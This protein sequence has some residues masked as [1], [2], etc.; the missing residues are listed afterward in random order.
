LPKEIEHAWLWYFP[1]SELS[2][3]QYP[4]SVAVL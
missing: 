2:S 3:Q 4:L 1:S